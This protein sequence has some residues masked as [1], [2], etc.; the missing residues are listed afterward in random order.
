MYLNSHYLISGSALLWIYHHHR[1]QFLLVRNSFL[2]AMIL[3]LVGYALFPTAPPRLMPEWGFADTVA[4]ATGISASRQQSSALINLYAAVPSMHVCFALLVG[5]WM[6][7]VVQIRLGRWAWRLYPMLVVWVVVVTGN[8]YL[9]DAVL[10]ALVAI[11][12]VAAAY[13]LRAGLA[14]PSDKLQS[15][16]KD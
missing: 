3:A 12:S 2:I 14:W 16:A 1:E 13:V 10:G 7:S 6:S 4:Q 15:V 5:G 9:F 8:H 11:V